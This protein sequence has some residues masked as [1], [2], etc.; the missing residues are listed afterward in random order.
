MTSVSAARPRI[1]R[2]EDSEGDQTDED[3]DGDNDH[4]N[5]SAVA[6]TSERTPSL[7]EIPTLINAFPYPTVKLWRHLIAPA[8]EV[9]ELKNTITGLLTH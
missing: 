9:R 6:F 5:E 2:E 3:E 8:R 1:A 4:A 7:S